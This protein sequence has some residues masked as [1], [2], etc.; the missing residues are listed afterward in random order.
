M[1]SAH[2]FSDIEPLL[3][4]QTVRSKLKSEL[5]PFLAENKKYRTTLEEKRNEIKPLQENMQKH[6]AANNAAREKG[7][8]LCSSQEELN[9]LVRFE[10]KHF[11][12]CYYLFLV[13]K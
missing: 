11:Y 1:N 7:M 13:L 2:S 10:F 6:R 8:G 4:M 9:D 12:V 3:F 5:Q